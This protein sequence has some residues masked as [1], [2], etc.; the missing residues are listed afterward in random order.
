MIVSQT[1]LIKFL[2]EK[3]NNITLQFLRNFWPESK[4]GDQVLLAVLYEL[5]L[6]FITNEKFAL[7]YL[8]Y[9]T[10]VQLKAYKFKMR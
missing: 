2:D 1:I 5:T 6:K 3:N 9:E 8:R 4:V 7:H 10:M